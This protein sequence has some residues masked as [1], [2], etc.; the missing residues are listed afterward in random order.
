MFFGGLEANGEWISMSGSS[1]WFMQLEIHEIS[2]VY[3]AH[4]KLGGE[5]FF[6]MEF[7]CGQANFLRQVPRKD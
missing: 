3:F 6:S 7:G 4:V 1:H 5:H 2:L